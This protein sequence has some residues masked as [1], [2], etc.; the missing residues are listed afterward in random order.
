MVKFGLALGIA[1]VAAGAAGAEEKCPP[2]SMVGSFDTGPPDS[3]MAVD[4]LLDGTTAK[5]FVNTAGAVTMISA[6]KAD[7]MKLRRTKLPH[8]R[9]R[10][11]FGNELAS[12][13]TVASL[14]IGTMHSTDVRVLVNPSWP[15][16][17]QEVGAI[18]P[19]FLNQFDVDFDLGTRKMNLF[20]P[21]HCKGQVVYWTHDAVAAVPIRI[22]ASGHILIA[23]NADG[24]DVDAMIDTASSYSTMK[25]DGARTLLGVTQDSAGVTKVGPGPEGT[26]IYSY[27]FKTLT[28]AGLSFGNVTVHFIDDGGRS[29]SRFFKRTM[30]LGLR[31][32]SKLHLYVAYD[33]RMLYATA[34]GAH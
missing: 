29:N 5:L 17:F 32:L 31:E 22:D 21:R 11:A 18:G 34:A 6:A 16:A 33:E 1:L 10:D 3:G 26:T 14:Q 27:T 13:V 19:D 4:V 15:A 2:L 25:L 9:L 7:E 8:A 20:S 12:I 24:Q 23:A 30:T 28:L